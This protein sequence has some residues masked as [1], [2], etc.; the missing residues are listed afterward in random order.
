LRVHIDDVHARD[1][2]AALDSFFENCLQV[3]PGLIA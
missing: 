1:G 3:G 2:L